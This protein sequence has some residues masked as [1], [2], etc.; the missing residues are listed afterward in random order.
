MQT[1]RN[2]PQHFRSS[3]FVPKPISRACLVATKIAV[4]AATLGLLLAHSPSGD[5]PKACD[6]YPAEHVAYD[7]SGSCGSAGSIEIDA[8]A[9]SCDIWL[10]GDDVGLPHVGT[11]N[12]TPN[13][14]L[15]EG[16]FKLYDEQGTPRISCAGTKTAT[17]LLLVTCLDLD[18]EAR[19]TAELRK[20]P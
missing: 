10:S 6:A 2:S 4:L 12:E 3:D 5:A 9:G 13:G 7:V 18:T 20:K 17:D 16:N 8:A 14:R 15:D 1:S 11:R 19:C